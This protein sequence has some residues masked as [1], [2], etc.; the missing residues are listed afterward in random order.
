MKHFALLDPEKR[1]DT[2]RYDLHS[3][4][5]QLFTFKK[6][7][8]NLVKEKYLPKYFKDNEYL[9]FSFVRHPFDRLVSAF[10]GIHSRLYLM[11]C[12]QVE[13]DMSCFGI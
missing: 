3:K 11:K 4:I 9:T 6:Q 12:V 1:Y 2:N 10:K 13:M 8:G 5:P 7:T